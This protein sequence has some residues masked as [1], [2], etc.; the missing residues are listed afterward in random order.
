MEAANRATNVKTESIGLEL[1]FEQRQSIQ[2]SIGF[3]IFTRKDIWHIGLCIP[4]YGTLD[5]FLK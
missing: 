3:I 1:P 5:E 2:K 4:E